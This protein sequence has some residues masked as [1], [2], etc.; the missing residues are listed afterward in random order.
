MEA[1]P[2]PSLLHFS[3]LTDEIVEL[4]DVELVLLLYF[5]S[6]ASALDRFR[7]MLVGAPVIDSVSI[8]V[9][10]LVSD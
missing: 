3:Q 8:F 6:D 1:L 4:H 5:A 7:W 2:C 9:E 10:V